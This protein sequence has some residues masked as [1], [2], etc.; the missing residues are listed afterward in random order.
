M[1]LVPTPDLAAARRLLA[2]EFPYA[3]EAIDTLLNDLVGRPTMK[4]EPTVLFG[5]PGAGKSRLARRLAAVLGMGLMRTD[6]ARADGNVFGGT[7]RRWYS[8]EPCHPFLAVSRSRTA[9]PMVFIDEIGKAATRNDYGRLWDCL[10]PFL[11][12]ETA[13]AYPDP[14]LQAELDLAQISYLLTSNDLD[15]LP[16]ELRDR[17]RVVVFPEPGAEHLDALLPALFADYLKTRNIDPVWAPPIA[18]V[19]RDVIATRWKGG[20]VRRLTALVAGVMRAR[21]KTVVR[22]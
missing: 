8:A 19:E 17:L 22:H 12:V 4:F 3:R 13:C 20:S 14:A 6:A 9:N 5:G 21:E 16:H 15:A 18:P 2:A 7:D 10:L 1:R 11:E